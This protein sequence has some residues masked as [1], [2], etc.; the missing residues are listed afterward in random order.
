MRDGIAYHETETFDRR[1]AAALWIKK[2]ERELAKP[3]IITAWRCCTYPA[4]D[5]SCESSVVAGWHEQTRTRDLQDPELAG[6]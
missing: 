6:L 2:R 5:S 1:P 3:G 4:K